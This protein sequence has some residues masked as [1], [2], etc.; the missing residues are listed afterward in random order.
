M[1]GAKGMTMNDSRPPKP[2]RRWYRFCLW[3]L[4]LG[5][6]GIS[7]CGPP[8]GERAVAACFR[9]PMSMPTTARPWANTGIPGRLCFTITI[10]TPGSGYTG[11]RE[12]IAVALLTRKIRESVMSVYN[13]AEH[14][15]RSR[16]RAAGPARTKREVRH[17]SVVLYRGGD[18][19]LSGL[20]VTG[21]H[22]PQYSSAPTQER[23]S[24]P[25]TNFCCC[26]TRTRSGGSRRRDY[27]SATP[28]NTDSPSSSLIPPSDV[29]QSPATSGKRR[30]APHP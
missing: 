13:P 27:H 19:L 9:L 29:V 8:W 23:S 28:E 11:G 26:Q 12:R 17:E 3:I 14:V 24:F 21:V 1:Q 20:T 30:G 18:V 16:R 7:G 22:S 4:P 25:D 2:K 5:L 10:K 6:L 15:C